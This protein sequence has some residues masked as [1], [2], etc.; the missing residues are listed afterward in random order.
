ML[1]QVVLT[2]ERFLAL[3]AREVLV[4]GVDNVMSRQV[5]VPLEPFLA[6]RAFEWSI[7]RMTT[8]MLV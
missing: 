1:I 5:L 6:H 8:H 2:R 3:A 4:A 7:V